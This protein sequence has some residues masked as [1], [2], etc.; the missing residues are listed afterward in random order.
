MMVTNPDET[1]D[2]YIDAGADYITVQY[3]AS[4]APAP[5]DQAH[6][7]ARLQGRR[8]LESRHSRLRS[9]E[10]IIEELDMVLVMSVN[11]G[12]GGQSYI[13][14]TYAKLRQLRGLCEAH[15]VS[16]LIEVD[17]GVSSKNIEQVVRAG[18]DVLVA[19][20]AVFGAD[21]PRAEV[22]LLRELGNRGLAVNA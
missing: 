16:P 20:S 13:E 4:R 8:C 18:A 7:R 21:D 9:R 10:S 11:P 17:G 2:W 15:G 14:S 22:D 6:P 19:G 3:E 5:Y 12:F 1:I